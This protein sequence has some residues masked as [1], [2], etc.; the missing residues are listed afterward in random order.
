MIS[1]IIFV[2]TTLFILTFIISLLKEYRCSK[3]C[4]LITGFAPRGFKYTYKTI[5]QRI[6]D[7]LKSRFHT[8]DVFHYSFLSKSGVIDSNRTGEDKME[9]N[10]DD[11]HLLDVKE[12]RTD[13]Q[14]DINFDQYV[15]TTCRTPSNHP[16][17]LKREL[18]QEYMTS[19]FPVQNYDA[20]I[21]L[22]SDAFILRDINIEHVNNVIN[23]NNLLYTTG[24]NKFYGLAN[25][26]YI[27]SPRVIMLLAQRIFYLSKKCEDFKKLQNPEQ[28]LQWW[29]R[30]L[31]I[32]NRHTDM[33]YVKI[34]SNLHTTWGKLLKNFLEKNP[35]FNNEFESVDD[36]QYKLKI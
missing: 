24:Y 13:Y 22:W 11:V 4:V 36:N 18:F 23:N 27:G 7:K 6:I 15:T 21:L 25:K 17:N 33:F 34:R 32:E 3:V 5:K 14:E 28:F 29:A 2:L 8:V 12:L 19:K 35:S 20:C 10:N 31:K 16:E 30:E 26:F 1:S 9:I